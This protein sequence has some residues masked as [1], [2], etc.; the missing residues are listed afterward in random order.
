[1]ARG[2][3]FQLP[4]NFE[5]PPSS[6]GEDFETLATLRRMPDGRVEL[7]AL[8]GTQL[9][10]G[11]DDTEGAEF[12]EEASLEEVPPQLPGTSPEEGVSALDAIESRLEGVPPS[13]LMI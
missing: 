12:D 6:D 10:A 1:M 2:L 9:H 11:S 13:E 4:D 3:T 8:D 5:V 7:I